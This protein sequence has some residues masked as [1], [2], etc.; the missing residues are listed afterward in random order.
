MIASRR[1]I[2]GLNNSQ[3]L[4]HRRENIFEQ[5]VLLNASRRYT[6]D[7]S[8]NSH[9]YLNNSL[10]GKF[11]E[12]PRKRRYSIKMVTDRGK[13]DC[14][15]RGTVWREKGL[16]RLERL[17][18]KCHTLVIEYYSLSINQY[19]IRHLTM[20]NSNNLFNCE[21]CPKMFQRKSTL[22]SHQQSHVTE[23]MGKIKCSQ[24]ESKLSNK[25]SLAVHYRNKHSAFPAVFPCEI[26][27]VPRSSKQQLVDHMNSI[28]TKS[29]EYPCQV[30]QKVF[31]T[32]LNLKKH[33][34]GMHGQVMNGLGSYNYSCDKCSFK[35][36]WSQSLSNHLDVIHSNGGV[37]C[38][39]CD[40]QKFST[41]T[42]Y[43]RHLKSKKHIDR[44]RYYFG[45]N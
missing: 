35:T 31:Y 42:T 16:T 11:C 37:R 7:G 2:A 14:V 39:I 29:V 21:Y 27:W 41:K 17:V 10:F 22:K 8:F 5:Y 43:N 24:C 30:C 38:D 32:K 34:V 28:H 26:C 40:R 18:T 45:R 25:N 19:N 36:N 23:I 6:T 20:N 3:R 1:Y 44:H 13:T 12:S 33:S 15:T 4:R 9:V